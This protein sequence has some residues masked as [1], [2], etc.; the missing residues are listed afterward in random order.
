MPSIRHTLKA[1]SAVFG[2][3]AVLLIVSP[4]TF[5][6]LLELNSDDTS[7]QWSMRM[8]GITLIALA[9]NMWSNSSNSSD[10]SIKRVGIVMA[11]SASSLGLLTLLIPA[12]LTWFSILYAIVGFGFGLSYVIALFR[13]NL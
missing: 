11:V 1:G 2:L 12:E 8:I 3:S 4:A 5:L 13:G 6:A 10:E 7:L 9:G